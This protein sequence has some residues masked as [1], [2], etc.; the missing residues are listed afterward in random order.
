MTASLLPA[1]RPKTE[2]AW[3]AAGPPGGYG[4]PG[5]AP[6]GGGWGPPAGGPPGQPFQQPY[7]PQ[8]PYGQQ[9]PYPPQQPYGQQQPYPPQ[10]PYGQPPQGY[11]PPQQPYGQ[12]A[13]GY[14]P[15]QQFGAPG[16]AASSG[17]RLNFSGTGAELFGKLIVSTLLLAVTLGLYFPWFICDMVSFFASKTTLGPTRRG[18]VRFD[19]KGKGGGFF[20]SFLVNY[21]LVIVTLGIYTPWAMCSITRWFTENFEAQTEDGGRQSARFAGTGGDLFVQFLVGY[22]LMIVTLG[23]YAPWFMCKMQKFFQGNT[24]LI[25]N[26][27]PIGKFDFVGEGGSLLGT[28]IVGYLL[29]I[30]T[31]GIYA[32]WFQ[33]NLKR[34]FAQNTRVHIYGRT[35]AGDFDGTGAELL[36]TFIVGYLLTVITVG[37]YGFWFIVNLR[38]FN[39]NHRTYRE[40]GGAAAPI[41]M[42]PPPGYA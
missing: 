39:D 31:L 1:S 21:L 5:G 32:A 40:I 25:E 22:L 28:F 3:N 19:F 10:Q 7:P 2:G 9:Q 17:L 6:P 29:T 18:V 26:G 4:P 23:I 30:I 27:Q 34:F 42:A 37:I 35:F 8:Q 13:Q 14:G 38:R 24:H 36:G 15:P 12:P 16:G 41:Q 20:V 33:C 11:G